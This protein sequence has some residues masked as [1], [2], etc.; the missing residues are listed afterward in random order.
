MV[1]LNGS[2]TYSKTVKISDLR[3]PLG[4]LLYPNPVSN[5]MVNIAVE[6]EPVKSVTV[7]SVSGVRIST[8]SFSTNLRTIQLN[9]GSLPKGVYVV[10]IIS[11]SSSTKNQLIIQ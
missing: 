8:A 4:I 2:F 10:D 7:S 3:K 9:V 5:G 6:N 1:N 11:Q